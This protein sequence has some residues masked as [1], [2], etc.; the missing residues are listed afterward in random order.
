MPKIRARLQHRLLTC[1]GSLGAP[2]GAFGHS[3][4]SVAVRIE[5]VVLLT[6]NVG[7]NTEHVRPHIGTVIAYL[8]A[9]VKQTAT[10]MYPGWTIVCCRG[11]RTYMSMSI[12]N[13]DAPD[14]QIIGA[15]LIDRAAT[16]RSLAAG[17]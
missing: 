2:T 16:P 15:P 13:R 9:S 5:Q 17:G 3:S 4:N 10:R 1:A 7:L 14:L 8:T 12:V 6:M 11:C